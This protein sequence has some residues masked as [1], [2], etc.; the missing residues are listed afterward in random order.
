MDTQSTIQILQRLV[1]FDTVSSN[2]NI[3]L[4]DWSANRLEA[5]GAQ[6]FVQHSEESGKANLFASIGPQDIPG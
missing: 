3:E 2:S 5:A 4:I 6:V 1:A